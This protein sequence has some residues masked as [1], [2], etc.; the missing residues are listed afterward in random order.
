MDRT[1]RPDS[2][3]EPPGE[4]VFWPPAATSRYR[5]P[6]ALYLNEIRHLP[7]LQ[8]GQEAE[9]ARR[10]QAGDFTARQEMIKRNLRLVVSIARR[11]L[12][13]GLPLADLIEEG[14]L[15]L[16]HATSRFDPQR[17]FRFSTYATWWIRQS[18]ERAVAQQVRLVRLPVHVVRAVSQ[19][20]RARRELEMLRGAGGMDGH[21]S[22]A[23]I[24]GLCGMPLQRVTELLRHADA[25]LSID[26]PLAG[27][28][29]DSLVDRL[30]DEQAQDPE[31]L[32][33]SHELHE[34][35]AR[36]LQLLS[37]R[38]QRVLQGRFGLEDSEPLTLDALAQQMHVTRERIRQIQQE[39]L[40]KLK[41]RLQR[42]GVDGG[43]LN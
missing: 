4:A 21:V 15:G 14:N 35:L 41:K 20:L 37:E 2:N 24:A 28:N 42:D 6:L 8:A 32:T 43:A 3:N 13:R 33:F 38:E 25:P 12:G 11:Y 29:D 31:R 23:D 5:D 7:L 30:G 26:A 39:A 18:V 19:V 16:M 9:I 40:A 22:A 34:H 36:D 17:G 27:D 1:S 10:V